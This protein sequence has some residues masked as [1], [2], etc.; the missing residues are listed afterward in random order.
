MEV[1]PPDFPGE[2]PGY[3]LEANLTMDEAR[4]IR[5]K[6][7][8]LKPHRPEKTEAEVRVVYDR[9]LGQRDCLIGLGYR[10]HEPPSFETF[11]SDWRGDGPWTPLDGV[12]TRVW[13][14][15]EYAEAKERCTL[16][17]YDRD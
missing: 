10:P 1:E 7:D 12:N 3:I 5:E 14:G 6:C 11:L 17:F 2:P 16:E 13:S 8:K 4:P 9:W 15:A